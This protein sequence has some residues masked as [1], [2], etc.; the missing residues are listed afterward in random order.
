MTTLP[1]KFSLSQDVQRQ[2]A[3]VFNKRLQGAKERFQERMQEALASKVAPM[4]TAPQPMAA[5][6]GGWTGDV[7]DLTQRSVLFWETLL[8]RGN[9][10][11]EHQRAGMPP[12]LHFDYETVLDAR[13]FARPVNYALLRITPPEGVETP[14]LV[15]VPH[16]GVYVDPESLAFTIAPARCIARDADLYVDRLFG[17]APSLGGRGRVYGPGG[18]GPGTPGRGDGGRCG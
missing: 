8:Q 2:L 13:T 16:A 10:Y 1:Q 3:V 4:A 6:G 12:V 11:V 15:E 14:V 18:Q 17:H 9:Q 5:L 7:T